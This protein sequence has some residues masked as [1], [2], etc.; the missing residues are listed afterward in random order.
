MALD[1][2]M[3]TGDVHRRLAAG[4]SIGAIADSISERQVKK[5]HPP[6]SVDAVAQYVE[7]TWLSA[8]GT[9]VSVYDAD[10]WEPPHYLTPDIHRRRAAGE[11]FERI[12]ETFNVRPAV[13]RQ[14]LRL[15]TPPVD[16]PPVDPMVDRPADGGR[17]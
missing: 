6:V 1:T 12:A 10:M 9:V 8:E 3:L 7:K 14:Y 13:I 15:T 2:S 17:Q 16:P 11:S 4:E 5:G